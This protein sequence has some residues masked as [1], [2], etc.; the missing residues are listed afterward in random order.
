MILTLHILSLTSIEKIFTILFVWKIVYYTFLKERLLISMSSKFDKMYTCCPVCKATNIQEYHRDF[1][2]NKISICRN[3]KVQFM[4]PVYSDSYL[5]EYYNN[6]T[7]ESSSQEV[8]DEQHFTANDYL[9]LVEKHLGRTGYMLDY[10]CGNGEHSKVGL[11]RGWDVTGYDVDCEIATRIANKLGFKY[12]CGSLSDVNSDDQK[13]DL[14]YANQVVEHLKDPIGALKLVHALLADNGVFL[15]AVPNIHSLSHRIKFFLEKMGFRKSKIGKYYDA[16]HHVF[17]Y[18]KRSVSNMLKVA[19]FEVIS[20]HN[21][22]KAKLNQNKL[23]K[24]IRR[25]VSEKIIPNSALFVLAKKANN[26]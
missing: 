6:Y 24:F 10:G 11:Q 15:V 22:K 17:Y 23:A 14:V 4:N 5:T 9:Q 19:G 3:C 7:G 1:N 18:D 12:L 13:F 2:G 20:K 8:I 21:S 16:E 25:N 26:L